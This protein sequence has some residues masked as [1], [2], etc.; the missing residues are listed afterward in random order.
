MI[1]ESITEVI[2]PAPFSIVEV[3]GGAQGKP[4]QQ[5]ELGADETHLLWRLV[6]TD[7]WNALVEIADLAGAPGET[8]ALRVDSGFLQ[9]KVPSAAFWTNLIAIADI[10]DPQVVEDAVEAY[11]VA[12]PAAPLVHTHTSSSVTDFSEA[13]RDQVAAFL[14]QGANVTIVHDDDGN[15]LTVSATGGGGGD[16][17]VIRDAIGA[18]IVG[19]G[20]ISVLVDDEAD[21]ITIVT[22]ATVNSTDA[23]LRDRATH[24]GTQSAD[25]LT[26]G[27]TRKAFLASERTKLAGV[28]TGATANDTDAN[29]KNRANHTGTQ[30]AATISDFDAAADARVVAGITGKAD[31]ASP[32]FTGNPTAPT[33]SPGDNDTTIATTAFVTAAVAAVGGGSTLELLHT[34]TAANSTTTAGAANTGQAESQLSGVWGIDTNRAYNVSGSSF[35]ADVWDSGVADG[36]F[37]VNLT[38]TTTGADREAMLVFRCSDVSNLLVVDVYRNSVGATTVSLFKR[39]GGTFTLLGSS[40]TVANAGTT[41]HNVTAI[42]AGNVVEVRWDQIPII[43]Y[44]GTTGQESATKAGIGGLNALGGV[45]FTLLAA[46]S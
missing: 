5:L 8:P 37:Q 17:E 26:D 30:L 27:T 41:T 34:F 2:A 28:A 7:E 44:E 16:A 23:A 4:G 13:V 19:L 10:V 11:M 38:F 3:L 36:T 46:R 1:P 40:V 29:L 42:C 9:A 33:P 22:T 20:V 15:T 32:A 12:H 24:T 43:I 18:A 45:R 25:T 14:A 21:T 6:G 35:M 39:I 31:L